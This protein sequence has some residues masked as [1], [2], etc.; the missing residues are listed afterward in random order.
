MPREHRLRLILAFA[1][2]YV[3][4]GS[5]YL[6]IR[7]AVATMPP[8]LMAAARF[9][10]AGSI[11]VGWARLR[12][13]PAPTRPEWRAA[14]VVGL[15][16]LLGGNGAV[17]WAEQRVTSSLAALIV[18]AEPL[19]VVILDWVRPGGKRPTLA[20]TVGLVVGF[21]GV[22]LLI[23]PGPVAG[24]GSVSA[25]GAVVLTFACISW[26]SGSIYA[27]HAPAPAS[28]LMA[29]G[30]NMLA[31]SAFF[32]AAATATG[33]FG[34]LDVAA[35]SGRSWLA[36][37]Y[38]T[39]FGAIIGFT[40]YLWLL[41]NTTLARASTYAYVNPVI[42]VFLGWLIAGEPLSAR[43]L[44]AAAIII[45][46]VVTISTFQYAQAGAQKLFTRGGAAALPSSV[47]GKPEDG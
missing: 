27:R 35:I 23:S 7:L 41:K 46:G 14:A 29:T 1:A 4:W 40:A 45:A 36:L 5:T 24:T 30:I 32:I 26:A 6:G 47:P 21:A 43:T 8:F 16:L 10:V 18:A 19:W 44:V 17:V 25:V 9:L 13:A 22:V 38:L 31:G 11:L 28:P 33:E 39:V 3:I 2:V 20:V 42:A 37:A 34:R 12:G 15:L